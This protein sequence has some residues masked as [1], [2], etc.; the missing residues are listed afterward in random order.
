MDAERDIEALAEIGGRWPGTDAERRAAGLLKGRLEQIG[1]D[2]ELESID[3]WPNWPVTYAA[4]AVVGVVGSVLSVSAPIAGAA[5]TFAALLVLFL[6]ATG[7][8]LTLRR[9]LGRRASQNVVSREGGDK[10]GVLVLVAHYDSGRSGAAFGRG[11]QERR[12]TFG[13]LVRRTIGPLEPLFW[14]MTAVFVCC[15]LRL[16]GLE[17][18]PLT[19]IQFIPTV[20]LILAV[21]PLVDVALSAPVPGANDNASGV[22]TVLRLAERHGGSL[23]HFDVWVLLTGA[24]EAVAQGMRGF[25]RQHRGALERDRTVFVNVDEVGL[26]TVRFARREGLL[27][28]SASH[29]QLV[30]LCEEIAEDDESAGAR[31]IVNRSASDGYAARSAG[32]PAITITCRNALDYTPGH[33]RPSDIPERIDPQALE[34]AEGFCDELLRRLD[35]EIGPDLERPVEEDTLL[36]EPSD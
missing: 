12:A 28:A 11:L 5:V 20:G 4:L 22:A 35:A 23:E 34:R 16:P 15:L 3:C 1:R 2:A 14:A 8:L 29:R 9:L 13:K 33:H 10:P 30:K 31:A 19:V 27:L 32:Y 18:T 26:G 21:P 17:G 7:L 36:S 25:V 24:Q 6:D